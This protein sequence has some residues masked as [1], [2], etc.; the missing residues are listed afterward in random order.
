VGAIESGKRATELDPVNPEYQEALLLWYQQ[1][2]VKQK[3]NN[4]FDLAEG[5]FLAATR[6]SPRYASVYNHL[7]ECQA[8]LG[9][10]QEAEVN[11]REAVRLDPGN[12]RYLRNLGVH[13][14]NQAKFAEAIPFLKDCIRIEQSDGKTYYFLGVAHARNGEFHFAEEALKAAIHLKNNEAAWHF[15]LGLILEKQ[16]KKS[17]A[18]REVSQ[19]ITLDPS[20]PD[21]LEAKNRLSLIEKPRLNSAMDI[22]LLDLRWDYQDSNSFVCE[23]QINRPAGTKVE[24]KFFAIQTGQIEKTTEIASTRITQKKNNEKTILSFRVLA[25]ILRRQ[26][27]QYQIIVYLNDKPAMVIP[28][29]IEGSTVFLNN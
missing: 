13:L 6:L 16:F 15:A 7:G 12:A 29:K 5:S 3:E 14:V 27:S 20:N 10:Q 22:Q 4:Q 24:A 25:S 26:T 18:L 28:F 9:K 17:E 8:Q 21:Y 19:A 11:L 2:G 1:L 23:V